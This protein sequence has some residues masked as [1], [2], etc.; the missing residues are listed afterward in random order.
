VLHPHP[1]HLPC[2]FVTTGF[3]EGARSGYEYGLAIGALEMLEA[4]TTADD[5]ARPQA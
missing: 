3:A 4:L 2:C 1:H 5:A